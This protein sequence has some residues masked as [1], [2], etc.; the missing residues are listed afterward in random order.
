MGSSYENSING[1]TVYWT[2]ITNVSFLVKICN[3]LAVFGLCTMCL[4]WYRFICRWWMVATLYREKP[5]NLA[6]RTRRSSWRRSIRLQRW[7]H[8]SD[9]SWLWITFLRIYYNTTF[10]LLQFLD[11][12]PMLPLRIFLEFKSTLTIV[13]SGI[14]IPSN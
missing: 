2:L 1:S 14:P 4:H 12:S 5:Q 6:K 10:V 3:F 11:T 9:V 13:R 7:I 8:F